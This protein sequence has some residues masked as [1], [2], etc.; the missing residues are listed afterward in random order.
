M[1]KAL[2]VLENLESGEHRFLL[3]AGHL[4]KHAQVG[5]YRLRRLAQPRS[6][7]AIA[8]AIL[9]LHGAVWCAIGNGCLMHWRPPNG[10]LQE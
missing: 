10:N 6:R 8:A 1:L 2:G 7:T 9:A 3:V 4:I 5:V